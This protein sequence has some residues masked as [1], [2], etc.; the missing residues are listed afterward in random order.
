MIQKAERDESFQIELYDPDGGATLGKLT[1]C[2]IT[3]IND[4]GETVRR[5]FETFVIWSVTL[6]GK[7]KPVIVKLLS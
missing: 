5:T 2:I 1:K 7:D 3:I 6:K 4:E